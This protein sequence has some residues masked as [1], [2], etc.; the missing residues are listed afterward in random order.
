M[1]Q[2]SPTFRPAGG[3]AGH[4]GDV[5]LGRGGPGGHPGDPTLHPP[6]L[7]AGVWAGREE[8]AQ[9]RPRGTT[10]LRQEGRQETVEA[11]YTRWEDSQVEVDT[12]RWS[13]ACR[14]MLH[15]HPIG[16]D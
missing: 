9:L 8:V 6:L 3:E 5:R 2:V 13:E 4:G 15:W 12:S 14:R 16:A 10:F 11:Q 7:Q 1:P